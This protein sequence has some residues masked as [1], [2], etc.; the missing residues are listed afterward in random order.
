M[1]YVED[2]LN[3]KVGS[4]TGKNQKI[5]IAGF[6]MFARTSET[7]ELKS[8]APTTYLEDGSFVTDNIIKDPIVLTVSGT[9]GDVYLEK[10]NIQSVIDRTNS[11]IG[12]T[13][14]YLPQRT[15]SQLQRINGVLSDFRNQIRKVDRA[16]QTAQSVKASLFG[17][18]SPS[19]QLQKQFFDKMNMIYDAKTPVAVQMSHRVYSP[20][21]MVGCSFTEEAQSKELKFTLNFQEL[22]LAQLVY[23]LNQNLQKNPAEGVS[24]QVGANKNNGSQSGKTVTDESLLSWIGGK[25]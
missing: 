11:I 5:G 23:T 12:K 10:T 20:M 13:T 6:S 18:V 21:I 19:E 22:R 1:G 2:I 4:L 17:N 15:V 7:T 3:R 8:Q 25:L 9:V 14:E 24:N 16:I